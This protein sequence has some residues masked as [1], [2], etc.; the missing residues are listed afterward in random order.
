ME[1]LIDL[2]DD[3]LCLIPGYA[4][5]LPAVR[6]DLERRVLGLMAEAVESADDGDLIQYVHDRARQVLALGFKAEWF[7]EAVAIPEKIVA[8]L[9]ET[10]PESHFVW[11]SL[12][13]AQNAAW[14]VLAEE[15]RRVEAELHES[16]E[17]YRSAIVAAGAV[18][19]FIDYQTE[20]YR[21]IGQAIEN[22]TG[23]PA[24]EITPTLLGQ[25]I[26]ETILSGS[27]SGLT[28][29]E[30]ID[31]VRGGKTEEWKADYRLVDRHGA[32]H[33]LSDA[34][35]QVFDEHHKPVGAMGI[36]QDV[37]ERKQLER[38][39]Q[40]S[41]ERRGRQVQTSTEIAQE[42]AAA[43]A[44]DE[45]FKRVVTLIKERFGYYHAQLFRYDPAQDAVVL[46]SGYGEA[47]QKM[48][49]A[50]H[51]LPM[52]RGIVGTVAATGQPLLAS[53]VAQDK[54][55]RPNPNLPDTKGELAVPI[56]I[57]SGD[58]E[59]QLNTLK[60]FI[61]G[62]FDGFAVTA[63][64]PVAAARVT[65][66]AALRGTA[67]VG[68]AHDLGPENQSAF[69][70]A[71]NYQ[72]GYML[73]LQAGTWA[74]EH[75]AQGET[76]KLGMLNF[77]ASPDT[78]LRENGILDGISAVF[79]PQVEVV[80]S[81]S[82]GEAATLTSTTQA[83]LQA[84]PDLD[85]I[86]S[87]NDD[88]A[89]DAYE[90]ARAAGY[91]DPDRFFIG[92]IDGV[93]AALAAI[94]ENSVYQATVNQ[95]PEI[96]GILLARVLIAK[97]N[98]LSVRP[99]YRIKC[100]PINRSNV[101]KYLGP[102]RDTALLAEQEEI[103]ATGSLQ[104]LNGT[105]LRLGLSVISLANP[106]F[107]LLANSA[108]NEARRLGAQLSCHDPRRILGVL[109]VQSDRAGALSA[110]DQ[111]LLEGLCGQIAVAIETR[112]V[113]D[114]LR[115]R[116]EDL[117]AMLEFSP[118]AIGVVNV[119]TGLFEGVNRAAE[120]LYGL[121]REELIKVGP[122]QMSPE[123]QPDGRPS[124]DA[125]LEQIGAAL[126][127]ATPVF[128][129][130]HV[131]A[132]G[133]EIPCEVRLVG[134][135]GARSHLVR[136][137]VTDIAERKQAE[138]T[139]AAER[140]LIRTL[141][142]TIPDLIYAKDLESRFILANTA[143]AQ[144]M[145]AKT[146]DELLGK[147]DLDF[148]PHELA[149]QYLASEQPIVRE[150]QSL[151]GVEEP[152][153]DASGRTRWQITTKIP[154]RNE[155]GDIVGLVG[156]TTDITERKHTE[157]ELR[158]AQHFLNSVL[159][160]LPIMVFVKE[161]QD[162][163][164]VR[165]NKAGEDLVG[166]AREDML[167][168][169]D[170]DFFPQEEADFFVAKDREV[171]NGQILVDTPEEPIQTRY[172]GL[173]LLHTRKIPILDEQGHPQYLLGISEDITD[174]KQSEAERERMF[175]EQQKRARQLQAVSEVA[176][177]ASSI[178]RL[179]ELLPQAAEL[180]RT[181]FDLYYVGI[182]LTDE[183]GQWAE[184]RAGTG[185][186]GA[187]M[188]A[189]GHRLKIGGASMI[190]RCITRQEAQIALDVGEAAMRFDNPLLPSTRSE[191]ALPLISRGHV[192]GAIT[193]Q[194]D[195]AADFTPDDITILQTLTDQISTALDNVA[196]YEQ[197]Q[198]ALSEVDAINRRLTG[199]TWDAYLRG[200]TGQAVISAADDEQA[201]PD[202]LETLDPLFASGEVMVEPAEDNAAEA[203]VTAPILL[204]GQPIGALRM[205]TATD[206]WNDDLQAVLTDL[207][208]H[209]AQAVEN[210]RLIE[211]TQR[212]ASRERAINEINARVRQNI[213]LDSILRTAVT[214]LG[215]TLKAARVVARVSA[216]EDAAGEAQLIG[217]DNQPDGGN[218]RGEKH[219]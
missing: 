144:Q 22:Y 30:A 179:S 204:R 54:S 163:R 190:S 216:R 2:Y 104:T 153:I 81:A 126:H 23:Y 9:V 114:A 100:T 8:P 158:R 84:H 113:E 171:L 63:I 64:D 28:R 77:L 115:E 129:W 127:G 79:D 34:S 187:Q 97:I 96:I 112:R 24:H 136:F 51:Q 53:D 66:D 145:G 67:V 26:Q 38:E 1:D 12:N 14:Q 74:T 169:N 139:L 62:D 141:I 95:P 60:Y 196:L 71:D 143:T 29:A 39:I 6:Q 10:V 175:M 17:Q 69:I 173:R 72:L 42:I 61:N 200:R 168:K 151:I 217:A 89:L 166:F 50:G 92:G 199:D 184:L 98:G 90:A 21:F 108:Q 36:L 106:F 4:N 147:S 135:S 189:D 181:R 37:T 218:G 162:L 219:G 116:E 125:A 120:Q 210:A 32:T 65:H 43:P 57:G 35:I 68:I 195:R 73:G 111:L 148:Y 55:W 119:R 191:M 197:T 49:A 176:R 122:A 20:R 85:M 132:A 192:K 58:A 7:Q 13:R 170:Y 133:Q 215:Q 174:Q 182:F 18:P 19:Y 212:T 183:A 172:H 78:V 91:D 93:P 213:D 214:E 44:L 211:Q 25:L 52:G 86:V 82:V 11:R 41:L 83:W 121:P 3:H 149:L 188:L 103:Y 59:T 161:A 123:F 75:L 80:V 48:L 137:S 5:L 99:E 180:I 87:I 45:L 206:D 40:E 152:T 131:N 102:N 33:W 164:F 101:A 146:A 203:T 150:G 156:S 186:A 128:E 88:G 159:E 94:Q 160:N 185:A 142:D 177:A 107:A 134:L 178:L 130:V 157:E 140:N 105:G 198:V 193:F 207:A 76:L 56:T 194:S 15:R 27:D 154:L 208:G 202:S 70:F 167:G 165:W 31:K 201:A 118:E 124:L 138:A 109:D 205:K 16:E 47:G 155:A 209:V 46:V 110:E 117:D